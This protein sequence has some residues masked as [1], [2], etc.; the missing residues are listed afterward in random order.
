MVALQP[1]GQ[2]GGV[3]LLFGRNNS[4]GT[5]LLLPPGVTEGVKDDNDRLSYNG[6]DL[7][8]QQRK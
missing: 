6:P 7:H 1:T 2:A 5:V 8:C 3:T 4:P